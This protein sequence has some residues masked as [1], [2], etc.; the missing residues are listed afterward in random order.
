MQ[1]LKLYQL[2]LREA[3]VGFEFE[4]GP[5]TL[6]LDGEVVALSGS[7]AEQ[8]DQWKGLLSRIY[9]TQLGLPLLDTN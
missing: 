9:A 3:I 8:H 6:D 1:E 2:T 7:L 4:V 5:T